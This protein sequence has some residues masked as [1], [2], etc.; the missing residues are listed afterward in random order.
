MRC[1]KKVKTRLPCWRLRAVSPSVPAN[2]SNR[3]DLILW[4]HEGKT[5][6]ARRLTMAARAPNFS[7][8]VHDPPIP[9]SPNPTECPPRSHHHFHRRPQRTTPC[10]QSPT[11]NKSATPKVDTAHSHPKLIVCAPCTPSQWIAHLPEP[12][13]PGQSIITVTKPFF[14]STPLIQPPP[15]RR[16]FP[17]N[18]QPNIT[19]AAHRITSFSFVGH[20][21]SLE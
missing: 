11:R 12:S 4:Q 21:G 16:C 14:P 20:H 13:T 7:R 5:G 9:P 3:R 2:K 10:P 18:H 1:P 8:P 15:R 6:D 19:A 17:F